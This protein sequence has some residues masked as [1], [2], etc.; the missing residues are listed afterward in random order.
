MDGLDEVVVAGVVSLG[1]ILGAMGYVV[2]TANSNLRTLTTIVSLFGGAVIAGIFQAI[3]GTK[4]ALP[5]EVWLY[6]VGLLA[7][8][9]FA[10]L[11]PDRKSRQR[12][13][14]EHER[15]RDEYSERV[16]ARAN[17]RDEATKERIVHHIRNKVVNGRHVSVLSFHVLSEDLGIHAEWAK[18]IIAKYPSIL[19]H[20]TLNNGERGIGL[21]GHEP[22]E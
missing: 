13:R 12:E 8:I 4:A 9:Y 10:Y 16:A 22:I 1:A 18:Q 20:R 5:R 7:G 14:D 19:C 11:L 17:E 21:A 6:P 3:A 15:R 2:F